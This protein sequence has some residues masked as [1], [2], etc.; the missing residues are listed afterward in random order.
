[1]MAPADHIAR[2]EDAV[3]ELMA[4]VDELRATI[5][6][7]DQELDG[8][9]S[10]IASDAGAL[11]VLQ[12]VYADPRSTAATKTRAASAAIGFEISKPASVNLV[13]NFENRV[14]DA[15]LRTVELRKVEW[16]RQAQPQLDLP[17][18]GH[19]AEGEAL[20]PEPAA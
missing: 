20:G 17:I 19:D 10:W 3:R 12:S 18:L 7:K 2:L 14:R 5:G 6:R 11:E 9:I 13:V 4:E 16:A 1:M 15:R 8:L